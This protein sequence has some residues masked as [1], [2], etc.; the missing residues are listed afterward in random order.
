MSKTGH[1]NGALHQ[2]VLEIGRGIY[3]TVRQGL[4]AVAGRKIVGE[5]HSGDHTFA[6]DET[7]ER[8]L[9][10]LVQQTGRR[11][12]LRLAYYSE[13]R[14]LVEID[15]GA[16]HVLIIDPVD[17]TR[18]A[19]CGFESC[20]ASV[21]AAPLA[22]EVRMSS[23]QAACLVELGSGR[24]LHSVR[25]GGVRAVQPGQATSLDPVALSMRNSPDGMFW[26]HEV[27][28][29]AS[30][31]VC[32]LLGPLIDR[33]SHAGA[34]FVFNS[35]SYAISRV[36]TGQLDCYVDPYAALLNGPYAEEWR[37]HARALTGGKIF[38]LFPYDIA[39]AV[40]LAQQAG[41]HVTDARGRSIAGINLLD[42]SEQS[43]VSLLVTSN[44]PLAGEVLGWITERIDLPPPL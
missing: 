12:G 9:E 17:G 27:C 36:I 32:Q 41:C 42:S 29:R 6:L 18:P 44:S 8:A 13:D 38:G 14:G 35:S 7:A 24:A 20:C 34:C 23:I 33:S 39:A 16:T 3:D 10:P 11:Y 5:A 4:G 26:A 30:T 43:L 21:A 31:A 28:G 25:S 40:F 2:V 22:P 37:S 19:V 15:E 1:E